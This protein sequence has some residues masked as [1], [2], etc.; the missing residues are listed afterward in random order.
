MDIWNNSMSLPLTS[1]TWSQGMK[2]WA[3]TKHVSS[4]LLWS[5]NWN[6]TLDKE[7]VF[8]KGGVQLQPL[9]NLNS[10]N[11]KEWS[12]PSKWNTTK[13][14]KKQKACQ[15]VV[16]VSPV[17][18][19]SIQWVQLCFALSLQACILKV[20]IFVTKCKACFFAVAVIT[21]L[22]FT[23]DGEKIFSNEVECNCNCFWILTASTKSCG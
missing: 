3:S 18:F 5:H 9:S 4:L 8:S 14:P 22:K 13:A 19:K 6:S 15:N 16:T 12:A 2:W 17:C 10:L 21:Q 1:N 23:L 20:L 7:K 11:K